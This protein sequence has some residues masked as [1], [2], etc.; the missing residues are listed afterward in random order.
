MKARANHRVG[1]MVSAVMKSVTTQKQTPT[2][3]AQPTAIIKP[4]VSS[5]GPGA[6]VLA[7]VVKS[8]EATLATVALST[9][10][11]TTK[12]LVINRFLTIGGM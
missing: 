6:C 11:A 5:T 7:G 9:V 1:G 8:S 10:P 4:N 2:I 12:A 3:E